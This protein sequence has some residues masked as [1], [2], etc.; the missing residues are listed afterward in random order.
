MFREWLW[1]AITRATSLDN[2][3]FY[4]YKEPALNKDLILSYFKRRIEGYKEQDMTR[5]KEKRLPQEVK[6]KY[7]T[8]Q[9]LVSC[10]NKLCPSC[11]DSLYIGFKDGNTYTNITADRIDNSLYH[12]IDNIQPMCKVCNCGYGN[13]E[14]NN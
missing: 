2:V 1:T 4:E 7:V 10:A 8:P 14:K 9:W 6:D 3:Y 11:N 12:T 13:R 5:I